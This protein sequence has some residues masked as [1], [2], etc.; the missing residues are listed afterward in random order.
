M[1]NPPKSKEPQNIF[2]ATSL[3]PCI[4][5]GLPCVVFVNI[6]MILPEEGISPVQAIHIGCS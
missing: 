5:D 4:K 1:E 2:L 6:Y 3:S